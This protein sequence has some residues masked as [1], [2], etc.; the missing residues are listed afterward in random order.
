MTS[1]THVPETPPRR[2]SAPR[3]AKRRGRAGRVA[4]MVALAGVLFVGTGATLSY[5]DIQ[6]NISREDID[7]LLGRDEE[8]E[9]T[10]VDPQPGEP[11]NFLVLGSD[12]RSGD[13]DVDG[14]GAAGE[15]TGMRADTTMIV[16]VSADRDRMDVVSIPRDTLVEIPACRLPDGTVTESHT[17]MFNSAFSI[18]GATGSVGS[19]AACSIRTVE[20]LTGLTIDDFVVVDF[21]GFVNV[22]DALDGIAVHVPE[23]VDDPLYTGLQ[24]EAGCQVLDG[25]TALAYARVRH[26]VGRG[27]D[28][29][30]ISRQQDVVEAVSQEVLGRDI[31]TDLPSLYAFLDA[32]TQSLTTGSELGS[33]TTLAGLANSVRGLESEDITFVTMPFEPAGPRVV[34]TSESRELFA[35][36]RAD[37]PVAD[38]A[39]DTPDDTST[40]GAPDATPSS[41]TTPSPDATSTPTTPVCRK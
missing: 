11:L 5:A 18:G 22:I 24:L 10:A 17:G 25:R 28:I 39:D 23:E 36:L 29:A 27:G 37:R 7:S 26:G 32:A 31:L 21:A 12:E 16:H 2:L 9:P 1:H 14:A 3:H 41:D 15:V 19:A 33:L 30:R 6:G 40:Q 35:D 4:G 38:P 8:E 13:S 34:P 20:R